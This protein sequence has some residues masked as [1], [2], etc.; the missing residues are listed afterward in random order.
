V[1]E[2]WRLVGA[3]LLGALISFGTTFYFERRKEQRAEQAEEHQRRKRIRQAT[4]LVLEELQANWML[5]E[6]ASEGQWWSNPPHDLDQHVWREYRATLALEMEDEFE[7]ERVTT[8]Q[9][10]I[11]DLNRRLLISKTEGASTRNFQGSIADPWVRLI[12]DIRD[13]VRHGVDALGS[14]L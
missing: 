7:W 1:G 6:W 12:N 13:P 10:K 9:V 8:A 3:T 4:R 5:L 11:E 14:M 2:F